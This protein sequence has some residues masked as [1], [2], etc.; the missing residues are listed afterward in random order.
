MFFK[1]GKGITDLKSALKNMFAENLVEKKEEF[2]NTFSSERLY[3]KSV[4]SSGVALEQPT[5]NGRSSD[6]SKNS[7]GEASDFEVFKVA[8]EPVGHL[9]SRLVPLVLLLIDGSNPID[10]ND[11]RWEI[12]MVV[13]KTADLQEDIGIN[14]IGF[15]AV[16]RFHRYPDSQRLRLGQILVLPPYQGKGYGG[17]LLKVLNNVAVSE[18]VYDLTVEEPEDSLQHVRTKIDLQRLL[19]FSPI[20]NALSAVVSRIKSENPSKRSEPCQYGPPRSAVEDVRKSLKIN[21]RQFLQC[22]E[23]LLYLGLDPIDKYMESYRAIVTARIKTDIIGKD[24]EVV[25]KRIIDVP[26]EFDQETSFAMFKSQN[27]NVTGSESDGAKSNQEE[28]LRQLVDE[29]MK[30]IKLIAEKVSMSTR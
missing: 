27:G 30:E 11:P 25:G 13:R 21:K 3:I 10:I 9:Y 7:K 20:Q 22:W 8:G 16:Y 26:T 29:R 1:G 12:Y 24:S 19:V 23:I 28:S 2:L 14:M 15:A 5:A 6:S 18:D 4:I 17:S